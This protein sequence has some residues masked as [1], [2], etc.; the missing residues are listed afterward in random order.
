MPFRHVAMFKWTD[1]VD[2]DHVDRISAS[3]STLPSEI[4]VIRNYVHGA[5]AGVSDGAYDYVVMADFDNVDDFRTYRD[6][7][8]HVAVIDEHIKGHVAERAAMQHETGPR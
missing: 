6:H 2:A 4:D 8:R 3:L 7:P 5:D 1:D